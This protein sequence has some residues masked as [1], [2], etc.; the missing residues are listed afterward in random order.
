M[1]RGP[2]LRKFITVLIIFSSLSLNAAL[3]ADDLLK[4][5][6]QGRGGIAVGMEWTAEIETF[7]DSEKSVRK[8]NVK[9]LDHDAYVEAKEP[10]KN[11]GEVYI[12]NDR[13]M[14]FYKPSLKKP[15]SISARQKLSG[16][17]SNGDIASTHY[18]RD[19]S[20]V[21]ERRENL[22]GE[23][24]YVLLLKAKS[25]NLTY[26]QIRYWISAKSKLAEKAEFLTL[27]G[28]PFKVGVLEY[29]NK[30]NVNG[31]PIAFVSSM[32]ITDSKFPENKSIIRYSAPRTV[33]HS[34]SLF[35]V[36]NLTR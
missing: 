36:N 25:K 34:S 3:S 33:A 2:E 13:N 8:F 6:D 32:T 20:A 17:A 9:T 4:A 11:K 28:K 27:Q 15:V 23:D 26:D 21:L 22:N 30:L 18:A 12:F 7:E 29:L 19:Y 16:Q 5:S 1:I 31:K 24:F 10:A 35:N 14:W